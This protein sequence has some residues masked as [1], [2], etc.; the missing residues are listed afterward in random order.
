MYI[1]THNQKN[2]DYIA[3]NL[4]QSYQI[5]E[6]DILLN[7]LTEDTIYLGIDNIQ[8]PSYINILNLYNTTLKDIHYDL[9]PNKQ[10][11]EQKNNKKRRVKFIYNIIYDLLDHDKYNL[12]LEIDK[13]FNDKIIDEQEKI[14]DNSDN[15]ESDND[16]SDND[17]SDNDESDNDE[18]DN[19]ESDNDESDND[20][21]DN[22]NSD[23]ESDNDE[24]DNDESDNDETDN[25]ENYVALKWDDK[26]IN[27][28]YP[29]D[30][31]CIYDNSN[32]C[33]YN[34]MFINSMM[35]LFGFSCCY[36]FH[37]EPL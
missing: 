21:S 3:L 32:G 26:N 34:S 16:E 36:F 11:R 28:L 6:H 30:S 10:F 13:Y 22:D 20:E 19:D 18:S 5:I 12:K 2:N 15:D 35:F 8:H 31:L 7:E 27:I 1:I 14:V 9:Y 37:H 29:D 24:S 25:S 17:E 4:C 33:V 23:N